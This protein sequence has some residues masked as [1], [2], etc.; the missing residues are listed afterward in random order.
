[1]LFRSI[2]KDQ[3]TGKPL[4]GARVALSSSYF[5]ETSVKG[6]YQLSQVPVGQVQLT[7]SCDGYEPGRPRVKV[8]LHQTAELDVELVPKPP[9]PG[10]AAAPASTPAPAVTATPKPEPAASGG[11]DADRL[12]AKGRNCESSRLWGKALDAYREVLK[13]FPG[14]AQAEAADERIQAVEAVI[15]DSP[16][17]K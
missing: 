17:N 15:G 3:A 16:G 9:D 11:A 1:M 7:V 2:V 12:L 8:E 10:K 13:Q 14:T 4:P 5:D 6:F